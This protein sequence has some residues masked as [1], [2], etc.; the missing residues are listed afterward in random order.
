MSKKCPIL[1][2]SWLHR[3]FHTFCRRTVR[4]SNFRI[5]VQKMSNF[6]SVVFWGCSH[7]VAARYIVTKPNRPKMSKNRSSRTFYFFFLFFHGKSVTPSNFFFFKKNR[8]LK[9]SEI[10][11]LFLGDVKNPIYHYKNEIIK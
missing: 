9:T 5:F 7:P 8:K 11:V 6:L 3:L 1:A 4:Q 10:S 2:I